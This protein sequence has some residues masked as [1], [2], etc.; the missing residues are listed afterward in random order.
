MTQLSDIYYVLLRCN[1]ISNIC[2]P[3]AADYIICDSIKRRA[4]YNEKFLSLLFRSLE[5][6]ASQRSRRPGVNFINVKRAHFS[7]ERLFSSYVLALN[8]LSYEKFARLTLMKLTADHLEHETTSRD[9]LPPAHLLLHSSNSL[10][11]SK[12]TSQVF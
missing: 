8:E 12:M 7:Y 9:R 2:L 4:L 10:S 6:R 1:G 3:Y 11:S 5:H